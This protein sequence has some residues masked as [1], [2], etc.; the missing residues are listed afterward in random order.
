MR[1]LQIDAGREMRGGQWQVLRLMEGLTAAGVET[2][3][4]ARADSPLFERAQERGLRV[5]RLELASLREGAELVHAHDARSHAL[6]VS[7]A[8]APVVV[9]R[10]VAFPIRTGLLSRWKYRRAAHFIAVSE[11]V[12]KLLVE[13]GIPM[14]KISV[15]YDGVPIPP[16]AR[17]SDRRILAPRPSADKPAELYGQ[18]GLE[19]SFAE[20]LEADLKTASLFVYMSNSEGLG[21]GVLLAM[22]AGVPVIASK[23]GGIPEIIRHEENGLLVDTEP[24]AVAVAVHRLQDDPALASRLAARGR[25]TVSE[26]FSIEIMVRNTLAVYH[27]V[28]AC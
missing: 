6:A 21:S 9:S 19:I 27:R 12:R 11:F 7:L 1:I 14:E 8:R 26:R 23:T 22:A 10:R 15:V 16:A 13:Y 2:W 28:L 5:A 3:L 18:T 4:A 17:R 25:Q 20:N 24:G